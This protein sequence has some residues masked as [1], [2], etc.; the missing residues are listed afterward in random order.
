KCEVRSAKCEVRNGERAKA[1]KTPEQILSL[2][3]CDPAMGSGSFLVSAL[4]YLTEA[5]LESLHYHGRLEARADRTLCRLADGK[6]AEDPSQE[7]LPVPHDHPEFEDRL[8]ARLKRHVVERCIYGVDI[9]PLAVELA[10]MSLWVET[11]DPRLPFGF[12]DHKLKCGN[13]LVGC[14]FDRFQD[15]PVMAWEREGGDKTHNQFV[16]HYREYEIRRGGKKGQ[17]ERRGDPWTAAIKEGRK[18]AKLE[19]ADWITGQKAFQFLPAGRTP[20]GVHDQTLAVFGRLHSL[21]V[22]ETERQAEIF[23]EEIIADSDLRRLTEAFHTWC[24][25]W[26]WPGDKIDD[27]PLPS[28]FLQP[29]EGTNEIVGDLAARHRFFH[30]ELEFPDVF[31]RA[32]SGFDALLGNPPWE[33]QS[34]SGR[35]VIDLAHWLMRHLDDPALVLWLAKHGGQLHDDFAQ[36]VD[37]RLNKPAELERGGKRDELNK[38]RAGAPHAIPRPVLCTVW[39]FLLSGRIKSRSQDFALPAFPGAGTPGGAAM[40]GS[41]LSLSFFSWAPR[42]PSLRLSTACQRGVWRTGD[43]D[44]VL[45]GCGFEALIDTDLDLGGGAAQCGGDGSWGGGGRF[46]TLSRPWERRAA[47]ARPPAYATTDPVAP[48]PARTSPYPPASV[49]P[50]DG[51]PLFVTTSRGPNQQPC[52]GFCHSQWARVCWPIQAAACRGS[53][54]CRGR[55]EVAG[56]GSRRLFRKLS[57]DCLRKACGKMRARPRSLRHWVAANCGR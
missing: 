50:I 12:L 36:L 25:I 18:R 41:D 53:R 39:R 31:A 14:W 33:I 43:M 3:V 1:P 23:S 27:A 29:P 34:Q 4:R 52:G 42:R 9:D 6:P 38:I 40:A 26:F 46:D 47:G 7:L 48:R 32:G 8:R 37:H 45:S 20:E 44:G 51:R 15:Y 30:W 16:S 10:R 13:S 11:M 19:M 54:H 22:H 57:E 56:G 21:S 24:A 35:Q 2:K 17:T 49:E 28:N 5:L 55:G